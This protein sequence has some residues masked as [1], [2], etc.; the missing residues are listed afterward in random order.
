M[1]HPLMLASKL[2]RLPEFSS[3]NL[4]AAILPYQTDH[5]SVRLEMTQ[6]EWY[7][8]TTNHSNT[9]PNPNYQSILI[10]II[11]ILPILRKKEGA[12]CRSLM[13]PPNFASA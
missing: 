7:M 8:P 2:E 5:C 9:N 13:A 12:V 3:A 1:R 10:L 11:R 4:V 6:I